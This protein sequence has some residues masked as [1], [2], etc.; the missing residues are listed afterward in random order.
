[1][2]SDH[3]WNDIKPKDRARY[4]K[5]F[6]E[7]LQRENIVLDNWAWI[8]TGESTCED[9][10]TTTAAVVLRIPWRTWNKCL[11]ASGNWPFAEPPK[12]SVRQS[13]EEDINR[14]IAAAYGDWD[15]P[16]NIGGFAFAPDPLY[17]KGTVSTCDMCH[18]RITTAFVDGKT[19]MGPWA[20]MCPTFWRN[21][22]VDR[23]GI[24]FSQ[25]Y[26]KQPDGRF[27]NVEGGPR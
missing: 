26:K 17:L 4:Q 11:F 15:D 7:I 2:I 24:G 9:D 14:Q 22:G 13:S 5:L 27:L 1:M 3:H 18:K 12:D 21:Y 25:K 20:K 19:T 8:L 23:L 16:D 10:A 6:L